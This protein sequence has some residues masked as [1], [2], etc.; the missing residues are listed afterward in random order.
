MNS[1]LAHRRR[2]RVR[3]GNYLDT[4]PSGHIFTLDELGARFGRSTMSMAALIKEFVDTKVKKI[5][6]SR[7]G[8]C[9]Y[10]YQ[11]SIWIKL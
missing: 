7:G 6:E 1:M 5:R 10:N 9:S 2:L 3:I 8:H 4:L 11:P